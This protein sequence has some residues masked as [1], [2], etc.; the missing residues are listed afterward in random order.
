MK[1]FCIDKKDGVCEALSLFNF[2][3]TAQFKIF[4]ED[5]MRYLKSEEIIKIYGTC[6]D[7]NL[8]PYMSLWFQLEAS[9]GKSH[10]IS[11]TI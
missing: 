6:N 11:I 4:M 9:N 5:V 1:G 2:G 7:K 8:K 3:D 10:L